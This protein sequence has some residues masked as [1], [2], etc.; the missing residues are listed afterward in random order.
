MG[1]NNIN[2]STGSP[3]NDLLSQL[4]KS[5]KKQY[6][7]NKSG[8][9]FSDLDKLAVWDKARHLPGNSPNIWRQDACGAPIC[10]DHYGDTTKSTGWEI[11]HILPS[12]KGGSD[13]LNNLQPLQWENNRFK[14]DKLT[15]AYCVVPKKA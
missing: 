2:S 4:T 14:S 1:P 15:N 11:D 6:G 12:E 10:W 9:S 5:N 7:K 13:Q 3:L 8:A